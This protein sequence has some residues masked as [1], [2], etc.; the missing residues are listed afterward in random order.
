MALNG[1]NRQ[2][3]VFWVAWAEKIDR[4]SQKHFPHLRQAALKKRKLFARESHLP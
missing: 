2:K 4:L 3:C 1:K